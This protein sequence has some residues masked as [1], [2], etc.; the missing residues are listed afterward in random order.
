MRSRV[1]GSVI[2]ASIFIGGYAIVQG[3]GGGGANW[4]GTFDCYGTTGCTNLPN[5]AS[6]TSTI[7]S[8]LQTALNNATGGE[9]ICLS[10][11]SSYGAI[12]LTSKTYSS[13]VTVQPASNVS[14]TVGATTYNNVDRLHFTGNGGGTA[15]MSI[16]GNDVDGSSGNSLDITF[17]HITY[18]APVNIKVRSGATNMNLLWDHDRF[19][20]LTSGNFEGRISISGPNSDNGASSGIVFSNSHIA[21][22]PGG[23]PVASDGF[24]LDNDVRGVQIGPGNEFTN[25]HQSDCGAVH[26]DA[27][28]GFSSINTVV[29]SNYFHDN[30]GA[31]GSILSDIE[32]GQIVKNNVVEGSMFYAID[33]KGPDA[34]SYTHNFF[35]SD[36]ADDDYVRWDEISNESTW[37]SNNLLRDN[38]FRYTCLSLGSNPGSVTTDHNVGSGGTGCTITGPPVIV[39]GGSPSSYYDYELASGS[40]GY[41]AGSDGKSVGICSTCG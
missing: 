29:T 22:E 38:A 5:P 14:A 3:G 41:N 30:G 11:A 10:S 40:P 39:G 17:D 34:Q 35:T 6:C 13:A 19:D 37:G 26:C 2:A 28:G 1:V 32:P 21:G 20:N 9:V 18:T 27:I 8:G 16:A 25:I 31:S 33:V 7:S 36:V 23:G 24:Y 4:A 15:T 12:S